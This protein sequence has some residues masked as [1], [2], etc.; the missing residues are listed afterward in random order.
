MSTTKPRDLRKERF[1]RRSL[2][3]W[4]NSGLGIA[5]FCRQQGLSAPSFYAW[6]RTLS[7]RDAAAAHFVPVRVLAETISR[8][9]GSATTGLELVLEGGR[10]LRIGPAFDDATLRRLLSVLE[11]GKPC[12]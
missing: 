12:S 11:E 6:R 10:R 1:W 9:T 5:E 4:G 3:E 7:Q 8:A 2:H